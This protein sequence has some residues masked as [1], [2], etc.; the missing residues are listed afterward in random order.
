MDVIRTHM[1]SEDF[2]VSAHADL[3]DQ[4]SRSFGYLSA[5]YF[6]SIFGHPY[7]MVLNIIDGVC[8]LPLFGHITSSLAVGR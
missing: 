3:P 8:T 2:D 7:E 4:A 5:Q 6:V 1:P